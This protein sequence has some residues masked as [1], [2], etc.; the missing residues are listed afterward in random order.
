M[1]I[2][3]SNWFVDFRRLWLLDFLSLL[4]NVTGFVLYMVI[5]LLVRIC[6]WTGWRCSKCHLLVSPATAWC[7]VK[8]YYRCWFL[9]MCSIY[10]WQIGSSWLS[11]ISIAD[12]VSVYS[13]S[14]SLFMISIWSVIVSIN[15]LLC[16]SSDILKSKLRPR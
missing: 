12:R 7:A 2:N 4:L 16:L 6:V 1:N 11:I 15:S 13:L 9:S 10:S 5:S 8:L 14:G 3:N